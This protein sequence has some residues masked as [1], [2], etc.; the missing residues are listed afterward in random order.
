MFNLGN[1]SSLK[2]NG[3]E[4]DNVLKKT[5]KVI[6]KHPKS[7]PTQPLRSSKKRSRDIPVPD[8]CYSKT[9]M[10]SPLSIAREAA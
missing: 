7:K 8:F 2:S 10:S 4:M 5:S 1:E 6:E 3:G 9:G